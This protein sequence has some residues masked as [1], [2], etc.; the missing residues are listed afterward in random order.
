MRW[1]L[2]GHHMDSI[3]GADVAPAPSLKDRAQIVS[4]VERQPRVLWYLNTLGLE[5]RQ[6]HLTQ[7]RTVRHGSHNAHIAAADAQPHQRKWNKATARSAAVGTR[8]TLDLGF[9]WGTWRFCHCGTHGDTE[10]RSSRPRDDI[11]PL[12]VRN[13]IWQPISLRERSERL[14]QR[15]PSAAAAEKGGERR[16]R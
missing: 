8:S 10:P 13:V 2:R 15:L 9:N 1:W 12:P 6:S 4:F 7:S 5:Q 16:R 11:G 14:E 3:A